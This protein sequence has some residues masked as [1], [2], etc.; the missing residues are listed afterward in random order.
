M[1]RRLT[2]PMYTQNNLFPAD[3]S[4]YVTAVHYHVST[5]N[6]CTGLMPLPNIYTLHYICSGRYKVGDKVLSLGD[7]FIVTP[8]TPLYELLSLTYSDSFVTMHIGGYIAA[9]FLLDNHISPHMHFFTQPHSVEITHL[10][11][12]VAC[13]EYHDRNVDRILTALLY[14][15]MSYHK[16]NES[17]TQNPFRAIRDFS[18]GQTN[19]INTILQYI[20][21]HY[22]EKLTVAQ[23][24][25]LVNLT[26]NYLSQT[27][28]KFFGVSLQLYIT[29]Y[30]IS[31]ADNLLSNT[32][33]P[34]KTIAEMIGYSDAQH[35]SQI[36]RRLMKY[37]P[38]EYR[39]LVTT[40]DKQ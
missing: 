26:P 25:D 35:F 17:E 10:I 9:K 16:P 1:K 32:A 37:S 11:K 38:S 23:L 31:I 13:S 21:V 39:K 3:K 34:I 8:E 29:K 27:F 36:F 5:H 18:K 24:A 19:Y 40:E 22:R 14:N 33:L 30:R 15:V 6:E 2:A 7:G 4:L 12:E 28:K 20:D